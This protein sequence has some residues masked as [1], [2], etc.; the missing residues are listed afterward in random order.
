MESLPYKTDLGYI[1]ALALFDKPSIN[2]GVISHKWIEY[3]PISQ[4]S[5][6]GV[7]EFM[8]PGTA[9]TYINLKCTT[10]HIKGKV[11]KKDGSDL[12][13]RDLVSLINAPLQSMWS[14]IDLSLQNKVINSEISTNYPYKSYIDLLL[15]Y[16]D[17]QLQLSS[18]L[19]FKDRAGYFDIIGPTN[20]GMFIRSKLV[21]NSQI[22]EMEAPLCLDFCEQDRYII[23]G[24]PIGLKFW[25]SNSEFYLRSDD[26]ESGFRFQITDAYL[27]VCMA[28]VSPGIL[29]GHAEGLKYSP[30][31]Y[32][33][34]QSN[35][36]G[37]SISAG[38]YEHSIDNIFQG[39]IPAEIIVGLVSSQA[40]SGEYSKN[41]FNF[42]H[43]DLNYCG[44]YVNGESVPKRPLEPNYSTGGDNGN[45]RNKRASRENRKPKETP[46]ESD[47]TDPPPKL[48]PPAQEEEDTHITSYVEAYLSLFGHEYDNSRTP[49]IEMRSYPNGYCL[50]KFQINQ[51]SDREDQLSLIRRG[52][53]RLHLK[54]KKPLPESVTVV[55]Y[56]RF[57]RT[58][59]IDQARNVFF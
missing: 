37:Y 35:V 3:R 11:V 24:V 2:T 53:T 26:I 54:F 51:D 15:N 7:L 58:L 56:A 29:V 22:I 38:V 45:N 47:P 10:L 40:F 5:N 13:K 43:Y 28:E 55:V 23:N 50:Y 41:P 17:N 16:N 49:S 19:F 14:Q 9:N 36:K 21:A 4:I 32:P 33:F 39:D 25:P 20:A 46:T 1:P 6:T 18:Q 48:L 57:P 44:F 59:Q 34:F 30:A 27:N 12:N 42:N 31:L 8:I 52:S